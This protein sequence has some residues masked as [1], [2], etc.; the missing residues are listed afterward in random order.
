[1]IKTTIKIINTV[2]ALYILYLGAK[3][4]YQLGADSATEEKL[5][6]GDGDDIKVFDGVVYKRVT[7]EQ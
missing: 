2:G 4:F 3:L 5:P 1:M 6:D 7:V